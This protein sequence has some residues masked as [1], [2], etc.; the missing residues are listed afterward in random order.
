MRVSL[1]RWWRLGPTVT[2]LLAAALVFAL[3]QAAQARSLLN[4]PGRH[5][6]Y[7]LELEPHLVLSPI[8][9]PG[10]G[11]GVG[12]GPGLRLSVPVL[13]RGFSPKLNDTVAV[14][15]GLD[16][17]FYD[18]DDAQ[19]GACTDFVSAPNGTRVCVEV[20]GQAGDSTYFYVPIVMQWN[21]WLHKRWSAFAEPGLALYFR[22]DDRDELDFGLSPVMQLGGR[23]HFAE[24]AALTFRMGYPTFSVGASFLF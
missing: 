19:R 15:V 10:A 17:V 7:T 8:D 21:L 9:P 23:W 20:D 5:P 4:Q 6:K 12:W 11:T 14:G 2:A 3:T 16:W 18:A 1:S 24:S 22:D 13:K